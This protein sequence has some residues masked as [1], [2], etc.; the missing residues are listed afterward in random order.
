MRMDKL[1]MQSGIEARVPFLDHK[2]IEFILTVPE[3][4]ILENFSGKPLLKNIAEKFISKEIIYRKKQGF[5]AP[6]SNWILKDFRLFTDKIY[7]FNATFEFFN[8]KEL[9]NLLKNNDI[10]KI[11][12]VYNLS[13]WHMSRIS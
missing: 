2:L 10:Q 8:K 1:V 9:D 11:W 3:N 7:D 6:I 5:R 13:N 12:Y 4:I